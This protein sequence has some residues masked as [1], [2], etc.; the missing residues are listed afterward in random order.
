MSDI[1]R[2]LCPRTRAERE[3]R[4]GYRRRRTAIKKLHE[5]E[6]FCGYEVWTLMRKDNKVFI[7][8]SASRSPEPPS[9]TEILET[10]PLPVIY[11]SG[12][13]EGQPKSPSPVAEGER[14]SGSNEA[15]Q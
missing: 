14:S 7:Y 2:A 4:K 3:R 13:A 9:Y 8:H 6:S 12:N 15:M 11:T 1:A 5:L 10:Y